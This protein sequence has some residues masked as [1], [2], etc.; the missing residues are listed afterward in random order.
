[1]DLYDL[2]QRLSE[3]SESERRYRAGE[4]FPWERHAATVEIEGHPMLRFPGNLVDNTSDWKLVYDWRE[5]FGSSGTPPCAGLIALRRS[6]RFNPTPEHIHRYIEMDYVYTGSCDLS[7]AGVPVHLKEDQVVVITS[8]CPHAIE[9][10]GETDIVINTFV[11]REFFMNSL[12]GRSSRL[13]PLTTLPTNR[14]YR[15]TETRSHVVFATANNR[16]VRRFFQELMCEFLEPSL[17]ADETVLG[18]FRLIL[19]ELVNTYEHQVASEAHADDGLAIPIIRYIEQNYL[20]CTEEGVARHFFISPG[21]VSTILKKHTG[22]TYQQLVQAQKLA[23]AA[24]LLR[25]TSLSVT[26]VARTSGYVNVSY[27]YRA[28]KRRFGCLPAA[29]RTRAE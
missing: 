1:M 3:L 10:I 6:S 21:Y 24:M 17:C 26:D 27:F 2:N 14:L 19:A 18:L 23:R 8:D 13:R 20:T 4:R 9:A 15:D 25:N 22:M 28:F 16:R 7:I 5:G 11:T 12:V 29:Y